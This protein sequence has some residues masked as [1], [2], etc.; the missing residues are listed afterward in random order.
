M[1]FQRVPVYKA[2]STLEVKYA[3]LI[4][5][6]LLLCRALIIDVLAEIFFQVINKLNESHQPSSL[7]R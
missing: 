2:R 4:D 5:A 6:K 7:T 1:S 3:K